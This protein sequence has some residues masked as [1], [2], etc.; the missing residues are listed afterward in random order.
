MCKEFAYNREQLAKLIFEEERFTR[1]SLM[2][3]YHARMG[4]HAP[5]DG[6]QTIPDY[7]HDLVDIGILHYQNGVF[8]VAAS[9]K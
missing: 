2:K 4:R 9:H 5:I 8:E 3:K 6:E 7:L 1:R